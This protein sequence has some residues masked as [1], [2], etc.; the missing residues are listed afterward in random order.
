V[1]KTYVA[2][3][4]DRVKILNL[5]EYEDR[6]IFGTV[7]SRGNTH[8]NVA[9]DA[10]GGNVTDLYDFELEKIESE[11]NYGLIQTLVIGECELPQG[12]F[13]GDKVKTYMYKLVDVIGMQVANIEQPFTIWE[14][15]SPNIIEFKQGVSAN[16]FIETSNISVHACD[17]Q[18]TI[19]ISIFTCKTHDLDKAITFSAEWWKGHCVQSTVVPVK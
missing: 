12:V 10:C 17:P 11:N 2:K 14:D 16:L 5:V 9:L 6:D 4:G 1:N 15:H 7:T 3:V 19:R 8:V 18:R 13:L